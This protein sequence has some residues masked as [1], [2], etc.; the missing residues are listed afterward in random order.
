MTMPTI[1]T[2][3]DDVTEAAGSNRG[4][5]DGVEEEKNV[6]WQLSGHH[7]ATSAKKTM[8]LL[9]YNLMIHHRFF[10]SLHR[11]RQ[12]PISFIFIN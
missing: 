7:D 11:H 3:E 8:Q 2:L 1:S 6:K 12:H 5:N 10:L 4:K 9:L